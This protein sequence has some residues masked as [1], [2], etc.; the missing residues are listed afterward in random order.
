M[1]DF[2]YDNLTEEQEEY[3]R[4]EYEYFD[5]WRE[6]EARMYDV[7]LEDYDYSRRVEDY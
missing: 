2:D 6:S 5:E 7:S 1:E 3:L 4:D